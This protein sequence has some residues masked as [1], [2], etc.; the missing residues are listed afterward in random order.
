M[1]HNDRINSEL[2]KICITRN[3]TKYAEGS[4]L[5]EYGDTKVLCNASVIAGVPK[6]VKGKNQG[7]ITAEYSMLPRATH[8]R[9]FREVVKGSVSGRTMEIQ[10]F[11]GRALRTVVKL[12]ELGEYTIIVDCDVIQADGGTRTASITGGCIAIYDAIRS[13]KSQGLILATKNPFNCLVAAVSV[14]IY[15]DEILL[16]LNYQEDSKA[17]IDLNIV[18]DEYGRLIEIQGTAEGQPF[19]KQQLQTMLEVAEPGINQLFLIQKSSVGL[20]S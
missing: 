18:M 12:S 19:S 5:I 13:M 2:R 14:G 1:R 8:D 15:K 17:Q 11:I 4:V 16:D 6:F 20:I 3:Y 10:R 9:I 7:W